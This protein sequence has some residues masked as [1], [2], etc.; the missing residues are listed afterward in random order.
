MNLGCFENRA[1]DVQLLVSLRYREL[2]K[3]SKEIE[4]SKQITAVYHLKHFDI[5]CQS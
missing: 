4:L 3:C 5:I 2:T 1:P